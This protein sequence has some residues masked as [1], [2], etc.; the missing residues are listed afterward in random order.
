MTTSSISET[1]PD[2]RAKTE[3][4]RG[5]IAAYVELTKPR[6]STMVLIT[7]W[8]AALVSGGVWD[9]LAVFHAIVGT[10]L[11]AA[12]GSALNQYIERFTDFAMPRT[13]QRPLPAQQLTASEVTIFGSVTFGIGL[14]YLATTVNLIA[15]VLGFVTWAI[16]VWI[17]TPLKRVT[18]FNTV[19]GAVSG[20]MP[21]LIG[22]AAVSAW[23][24][25]ATMTFFAVLFFWQFPHFMA[26]AWKYRQQYEEG[27]L[28]ML[29]NVE[30]T[31][32]AAGW[33]ALLTSISLLG[34]SLLPLMWIESRGI[35]IVFGATTLLFGLSYIYYS[36]R[37]FIDRNN[38]TAKSLLR[39]SLLYLP[40]YM[41]VLVVGTL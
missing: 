32:K 33:C 1:K 13:A 38:G 4:Q 26:I 31:G 16:Y 37:F 29:T 30:P 23:T 6:I 25:P 34:T 9:G 5:K 41:V 8:V 22:G 2:P 3:A 40:A 15:A 28:K 21:I 11:I 12:S 18:W 10:F 27:G 19:V 39:T 20:A 7:V 36:A 35:A 17:Y 14:V 24:T